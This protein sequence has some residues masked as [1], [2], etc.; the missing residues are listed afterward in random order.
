MPPAGEVERSANLSDATQKEISRWCCT[1]SDVSKRRH[2]F[3][4]ID[5]VCLS[6]WINV[7]RNSR[8]SRKPSE[9]RPGADESDETMSGRRL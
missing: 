7:M 1:L 8:I 2:S 4:T 6:F 5:S 3:S 9:L